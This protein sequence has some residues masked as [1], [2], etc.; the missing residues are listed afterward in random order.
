MRKLTA[1]L[2]LGLIA[3]TTAALGQAT[4]GG[5]QGAPPGAGRPGGPG[6][7]RGG[8]IFPRVPAL[9]FP[10]EARTFDTIHQRIRVVP[11][12]RGLEAPWSIAFL[13]GGE[14]LVT[15][16]PGR[17]R[18]VRNGVLDPAPVAGVPPVLSA[19]QGGLLE[20]L[21]HH[22]F[23]EN[24][25]IYLTYSKAGERGNTTALF[26]ARLDGNALIGGKDIFVADAWSQG[27]IHFG[28][29]LAWGRD[30]TLFMSVG[31]R[32]ERQRAQLLTDHAGKILRLRDDGTVPPDNPF[33][34][35]ADAKP[36]IYSYGHRNVQGLTVHP[37][38]G[39]LW[40][41]EH[42]PQGGDELNLIQ[43]G[44]NYGWPIITLGREYSGEIISPQP[45]REGMEQPVLFWAPS[46]GLSGMVFYTGDRLP[47][48][49]GNLFLGGLSGLYLQRVVFNGDRGP[50]GREPI[51]A[52]LRQRIRDVREGPD[53]LL[54]L[55]VDAPQAGILRIEPAEGTAT[56]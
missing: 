45:A 36:E 34:G 51:I 7:A 26:R 30:G 21:P 10:G 53:G 33:V 35:R 49:R 23:S 8:G 28:S 24:R 41:T 13:P 52:E 18:I 9:P 20:V 19:G 54:Y 11:Y 47:G 46:I 14:M 27:P 48:W 55:A 44:R 16:K 40:A 3:A 5:R 56:R 22:R 43:P 12:V 37:D 39:Q 4:Q 38:T 6:G 50:N 29:K 2:V 32:N 31:E 42:G 17:L 1:V 15:E 25:W